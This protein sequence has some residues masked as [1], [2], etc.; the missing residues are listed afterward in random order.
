MLAIN[1]MWSNTSPVTRRLD[2]D[3]AIYRLLLL[4]L[5]LAGFAVSTTA[6]TAFEQSA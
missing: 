1:W 6:P 3:A 4:D 2:P 5:K